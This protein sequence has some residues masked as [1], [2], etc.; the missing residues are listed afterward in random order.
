MTLL[1]LYHGPATPP[2]ASHEGWPEW[3]QGLGDKL[4]DRGS[5][6]VDGFVV[7]SGGTTSATAGSFNGYSL[8]NARDREEALSL[9]GDHPFLSQGSEYSIHVFEIPRG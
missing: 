9:I 2:D 5:P 6:L 7:H 3:F 8:V 1:L 4:V